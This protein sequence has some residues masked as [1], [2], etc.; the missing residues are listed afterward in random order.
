MSARS[1]VPVLFFSLAAWCAAQAPPPAKDAKPAEPETPSDTKAYTAANRIADTAKKIESLEQFKKDFP[2]ATMVRSA[3]Q[4]ILTMLV[5]KFP[6]QT[7]RIR[8]QAKITYKSADSAQK[9]RV[10]TQI[11]DTLLDGGILL[12]DAEEYAK[13]G[14]WSM[15]E[16]KFLAGQRASYAKRKAKAPSKEELAKRFRQER[17]ARVGTLGRVYL[18]EG[19]T[20]RAHAL[21]D[22]SYADDRN[23]PL[24]AGA[25]GELAAKAGDDSKALEY[26]VPARLSGKST[27]E[28]NALL[29]TVYRKINHGSLEGLDYMLDSEYR[30]IYPNPIEV[31]KYK[32]GPKRSDRVVLA[33]VFTG[34]GCPP[35]A[36]ADVAFDA[37]MERYARRDL[38]VVMYHVHVPRPDPMTNADTQARFKF[39]GVTGVPTYFIDGQKTMGG[40]DRSRAG[41]VYKKFEPEIEKDL[42]KP[43]EAQLKVDAAVSG[44]TVTVKA[45]TAGV[46]SEAKELKLQI[47]LVEKQI[48]YTGENSIRFHPLVVRAMGGKDGAGFAVD[49]AGEP[50][51]FEQTFDLDRISADLKKQLDDYEAKGHRG[52][53]FKFIEKKYEIDAANLGVVVFVQ[54]NKTKHVLQAAWVDLGGAKP[55]VTEN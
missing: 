40:D 11:A 13:T 51:S 17:A 45:S 43:A 48:R 50:A 38:A 2:K 46:K 47:A 37:A 36:G 30:K 19:H 16:S 24:V 18:K 5:K 21:L 27:P 35:C 7:D 15:R 20:E 3:N 53:P 42:E 41:E 12:K 6:D 10:A 26:L 52:E 34:S 32:P 22:E 8:K 29:E 55:P 54:D 49:A 4:T 25:L 28:A 9:G 1:T 33:E 23:Q 14:L 31:E 39:Y 44:R